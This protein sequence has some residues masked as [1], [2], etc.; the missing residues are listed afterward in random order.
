MIWVKFR[1][2]Y[3]LCI[4]FILSGCAGDEFDFC[5]DPIGATTIQRYDEGFICFQAE[6]N[7]CLQIQFNTSDYG[8][9][10]VLFTGHPIYGNI[11]DVGEV[12]CL[13][14]IRTKPPNS[15]YAIRKPMIEGH[16]YIMWLSDGTYGRFFLHSISGSSTNRTANIVWQYP[17]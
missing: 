1:L 12:E 3:A 4:S 11:A 8:L 13:G 17:F 14:S 10:C 15:Q 9:E 6:Y 16:G 2:T 5:S 7:G